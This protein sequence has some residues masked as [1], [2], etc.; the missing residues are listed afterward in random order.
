MAREAVCARE[1]PAGQ[2]LPPIRV[3]NP[4]VL[5]LPL[6]RWLCDPAFHQLCRCQNEFESLHGV[7]ALSISQRDLF[8][9]IVKYTRIP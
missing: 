2:A 5:G 8:W 1:V 9:D 3:G 6:D 4:A 7:F